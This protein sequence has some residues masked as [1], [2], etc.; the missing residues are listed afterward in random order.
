VSLVDILIVAGYLA[1]MLIV[2]LLHLKEASGDVHSYFLG[3][4]RIPWWI[5]AMSS[6]MSSIDI[7]GTM[8]NV[9][10]LYFMGV[11]SFYYNVWMIG[12]VALMCHLGRWIRRSNVVTAAEWMSFRF[13]EG[14]AGELPRLTVAAISIGSLI[15]YVAY[16]YVGVGKFISAFVPALSADPTVN[17]QIWGAL[18]ILFTAVYAVLGGLFSVAYTDLIQTFILFLT[19]VYITVA[20]FIKISPQTIASLTPAGWDILHPTTRIDYMEG[21]AMAGYPEGAFALFMPWVLMWGFQSLLSFFSGPGMGPGTQFMLSTR[22]ARDT[23]K[24]GAGYELLTFPKWTLV[25]GIT[26]LALTTTGIDIADTDMVLPQLI[27]TILPTGVKGFVLVGFLAAFMSTFS[28]S[29]N[30]GTSYV[31]RDIYIRHIRPAAGRSEFLTVTYLSSAVFV[32]LG[33]WLGMS[34]HSVLELGVWV[35]GILSGSMI[36]PLILRWY[37]WRFNGWGFAF[38]MIAAFAVALVQKVIQTHWGYVWPD[39]AFYFLM[40]SV[41]LGVSVAVTLL[42]PATGRPTLVEFYRRTQP[43]GNWGPV[44]QDL[45]S[46]EPAF[47]REKMLRWDLINCLV[48]AVAL[49]C[50]NMMPVYFMLHNWVMFFRLAVVFVLTAGTMY[51]TWYRTLPTD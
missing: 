34:M 25:V 14:W 19:S 10:I 50:L 40:C 27:S 43:W 32:V 6:S 41:S 36:V 29:I 4:R 22:S 20:A 12:G 45:K 26:L 28:I 9:S 48:G 13:G 33:V 31:I 30:N 5:T 17:A 42:T 47:I 15:G 49:F 21:V 24:Q 35:F 3:N 46:L 8:L 7:T 39:W 44:R 38:G 11:R 51:F 1:T 23:C 37:W 16:A 18:V 2:G